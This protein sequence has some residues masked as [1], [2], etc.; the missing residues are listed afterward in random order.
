MFV[1]AGVLQLSQAAN[2]AG[3][4]GTPDFA[5]AIAGAEVVFSG[6]ITKI[7]P[8]QSTTA[9]EYVATFKKHHGA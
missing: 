8:T 9:G 3:L 2:A 4:C 7:E 5:Q 1:F 6:K